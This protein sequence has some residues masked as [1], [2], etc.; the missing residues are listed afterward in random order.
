[1]T[2]SL[3]TAAKAG[4]IKA[5]EGLMNESFKAKGITVRVTSIDSSL[6][7]LLRGKEPPD[8]KFAALVKQDLQSIQPTG[9]EKASVVARAIEK[10]ILWTEE[11]SLESPNT[12]PKSTLSNT[13]ETL[14]QTKHNRNSGGKNF[15]LLLVLLGLA[16]VIGWFLFERAQPTPEAA[17]MQNAAEEINRTIEETDQQ[18]QEDSASSVTDK[19]PLTPQ[20]SD[21]FGDAVRSATQA[22]NLA[23]T[24]KASEEWSDVAKFW[25]EAIRYMQEVP[26]NNTNYAVAQT[27]ANEYQA[28]F[29]YAQQQETKGLPTPQ[30]KEPVK[31]AQLAP[32]IINVGVSDGGPVVVSMDVNCSNQTSRVIGSISAGSFTS[33]TPTPWE[34]SLL[35]QAVCRGDSTVGMDGVNFSIEY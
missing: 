16:G 33:I 17:S 10:Q 27:K 8:P 29:S 31:E 6:N 18:I 23:Q 30:P 19:S 9:F 13:P 26:A 14:S 5:I 3:K 34:E 32:D 21:P 12:E 22:A 20:V 15:T 35:A 4:D 24:A 1:M 2:D 28:N 11:W 25:S 7:I